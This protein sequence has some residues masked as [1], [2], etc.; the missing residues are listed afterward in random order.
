M[1]DRVAPLEMQA[2]EF[3]AVG[4]R[5]VDRI[6]A[7]LETMRTGPVTPGELPSQVRAALGQAALE[8]HG[9]DADRLIEQAATLLFEHSLFNGHPRFFG[10]IT[11]S[12]APIGALGD[13]L[14]AAV[15]PN[16]GA[17]QLSPMA[18][19]MEAQAVRWIAELVGY[20]ADCGGLMVSGGT[21]A[22]FVGILAARR[23]RATWDVRVQGLHG[24]PPLT[25]FATRETHTWL[26]KAA[27]LFG[28]GTGAVRWVPMD[29][30]NRMDTGALVA[31]I[32][33]DR[34]RGN[35]PFLVVGTAGSVSL[36]VVD[37]LAAMADIC[38]DEKLWF[39]VD[40]AYGAMGAILPDA[41]P[42][43]RAIARADS[44]ALD[45][46]KWLYAPLEAGCA[47]VRRSADM[48][49]AFSFHP[50]YYRFDADDS[51]RRTNYYEFGLQ[52][53]RGFRAL[54]VWLGLRHA[55]RQGLVRM[56]SDDVA[57]A[58]ELRAAVER[59][60]SLKLATRH[61]SICTF[62]YV[63]EDLTPGNPRDEEYL[64]RLNEELLKRLQ[65]GGE[66]FLSNAVLNGRFLLRACIVNFRTT[67]A[68]VRAVPGIVVRVGRGVDKEMRAVGAG[69]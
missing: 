43:L 7:L 27:D 8:E 25:V 65:A 19:E 56:V 47:L 30:S 21:M 29:S 1:P 26:E 12:A 23:A 53:S 15:N 5:L 60:A 50:E 9:V 49:A 40:G 6:A 13:L 59:E 14:G 22:N 18:S 57:L 58:E 54:K 44:L 42:D 66:A 62:R 33:E 68:D 3:R 37:P 28:F 35:E 20:P 24:G 46:H 4:H 32:R 48:V 17:W 63:P 31:A 11:S 67:S 41:S 39:H 69:P 45:P 52:N 34:A 64:N 36:G 38:R 55:G 10:Y 61:L 51:E 2:E 16:V